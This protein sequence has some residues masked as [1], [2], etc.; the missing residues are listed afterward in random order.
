V[1]A[2]EWQRVR[3]QKHT[4]QE[5]AFEQFHRVKGNVIVMMHLVH[6]DNIRV[7]ESLRAVKLTS[8]V[9]KDLGTL[10][11]VFIQDLYRDM[12]LVFRKVDAVPIQRL[13]DRAHSAT[14][15]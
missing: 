14:A 11:D 6:L 4:A 8:Q 9:C 3:T 2:T 15:Q 13:K 7:R 5:L 1:C 10:A 12:A